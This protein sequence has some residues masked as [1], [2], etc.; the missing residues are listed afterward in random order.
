[1]CASAV[2]SIDPGRRTV[3]VFRE[4]I[5]SLEIHVGTDTK[6]LASMTGTSENAQSAYH[7]RRLS[8]SADVDADLLEAMRMYMTMDLGIESTAAT[9]R[10]RAELDRNIPKSVVSSLASRGISI[11]GRNVLDL[12]A[13]LGGMSEELVL[14]GAQVTALEPGGAWAALTK[15]RVERHGGEFQLLEAYGES[16]PLP[17]QSMDLIVSL[18]VLEH[19]RNPNQVLVEVWRVLRPGGFFYLACE[20]YLAFWEGHYRLP[21]FPLLPKSIG[22]VYLKILGRSPKFLEESITYTT[23]PGVVGCCR[24]LGFIRMRDE[25]MARHLSTKQNTKW[26]LM[27]FLSLASG[28]HGPRFLDDAR[29][30]FKFGIHE[31]FRKPLD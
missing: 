19:V 6:A 15:R 25:E 27:K 12:G 30:W 1:V 3:D 22:K 21:W 4:K 29:N 10:A 8:G 9:Q 16:I 5:V 31:L 28:G 14:N 24:R 2:C 18:Q 17:D 11:S 7:S 13:G 23:F 20:N 26:R